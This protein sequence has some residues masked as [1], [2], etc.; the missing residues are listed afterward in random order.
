M[1]AMNIDITYLFVIKQFFEINVTVVN[2]IARELF[3]FKSP[4]TI[5]L[6]YRTVKPGLK[7]CWVHTTELRLPAPDYLTR[8]VVYADLPL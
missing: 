1:P 3:T 4:L 2:L 7:Q 6:N 8:P 5:Y